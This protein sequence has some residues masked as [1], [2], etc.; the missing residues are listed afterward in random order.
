MALL[1]PLWSPTPRMR[2]HGLEWRCVLMVEQSSPLQESVQVTLP[3]A[4][5]PEWFRSVAWCGYSL[6]TALTA[7]TDCF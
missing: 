2:N 7:S 1:A 4:L 3:H 5:L 6:H